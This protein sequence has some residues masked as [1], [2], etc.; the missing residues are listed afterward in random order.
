MPCIIN[1]ILVIAVGTTIAWLFAAFLFASYDWHLPILPCCILFLI[2]NRA[3]KNCP[4]IK[5][6]CAWTI[7]FGCLFGSVL[8]PGIRTTERILIDDGLFGFYDPFGYTNAALIGASIMLTI[9][10]VWEC[11]S[12]TVQQT[13]TVTATEIDE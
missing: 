9:F 4:R 3:F 1:S 6:H 13:V 11:V 8:C 10:A 7:L 12:D 5:S 2:A